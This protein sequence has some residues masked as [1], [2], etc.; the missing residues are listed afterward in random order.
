MSPDLRAKITRAAVGGAMGITL[1]LLPYLEGERNHPYLDVA[2]IETVC[3]GHTGHIEQRTYSPDECRAILNH[4][5]QS[6][7]GEIDRD[8][9]VPLSP[10]TKAALASF[11]FNVG[12]RA[13]RNSTLLRRINAGEGAAACDELMR[14]TYA[15]GRK[16]AGLSRRRI[17]ERDLCIEGFQS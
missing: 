13:F 2:G 3:V 6:A 8:V 17:V 10:K 4:D 15:G 7:F 12:N 9:K 5:L 11:T 14:W 16:V 1:V